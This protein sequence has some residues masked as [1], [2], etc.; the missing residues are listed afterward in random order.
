VLD[1]AA[2]GRD[3]DLFGGGDF[4][5]DEHLLGVEQVDRDGDGAPQVLPTFSITLRASS[6]PATAALHTSWMVMC[7]SCSELR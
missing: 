1:T 3:Q 2:D 4:T 6:S 7:F 5:G